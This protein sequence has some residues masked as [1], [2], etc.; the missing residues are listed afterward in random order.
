MSQKQH[1]QQCDEAEQQRLYH[2]S[3]RSYWTPERIRNA[4]VKDTHEETAIP[5]KKHQV[6]ACEEVAPTVV[7]DETRKTLPYKNVGQITFVSGREDY[8]ATAYV[9]KTA[10]GNNIVFTAA[11]NLYDDGLKSEKIMFTP[12]LQS[13][14][15]PVDEFGQFPQLAP[16]SWVV[17]SKWVSTNPKPRQYDIGA[18][19]LGKNAARKE[20][21]EVLP[22]FEI[23]TEPDA[24]QSGYVK[25]KTEWKTIG[26]P[27]NNMYE[28]DG[29]FIELDLRTTNGKTGYV[30]KR[31]NSVLEGMS[32]GPWL[33]KDKNGKFEKANGDQ[34]AHAVGS[35]TI[36]P[37]YAKETVDDILRQL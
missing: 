6:S 15:K 3:I 28:S 33:L 14:G 18:I 17:S 27:D 21:G 23:E 32:G 1:Q 13:D 19:K 2:D 20:V 11:H 35:Y 37:F 7:P 4:K 5:G 36:T 9:A 10:K 31:T 12:A 8:I 29:L 25:E 22:G 16:N 34:S 26:Y 24:Q 30:V